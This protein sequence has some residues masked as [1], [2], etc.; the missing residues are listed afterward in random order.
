MALRLSW[1]MF[2]VNEDTAK[3]CQCVIP[4]GVPDATIFNQLM[5]Q[6]YHVGIRIPPR[7]TQY[8]RITI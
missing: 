7:E 2:S 1:Y 4:D 5:K 3:H 8:I 6:A